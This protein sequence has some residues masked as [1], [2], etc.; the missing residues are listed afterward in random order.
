[1][2]AREIKEKIF[3][4]VVVILSLAAVLPVFHVFLS[5]IWNGLGVIMKAG[6]RFL[7]DVPPAPNAGLGGIAPSLAGTLLLAVLSSLLGIPLSLFAAVFAVEFPDN[8]LAKGVRVLSKALLE[9]PSVVV[10]MLVYAILVV[11][12]GRFSML[13]GALALA[14]MMIPYVTTYVEQALEGVPFTY[15]EAGFALGLSRPK[16]VFDIMVGIARRGILTG[17]LIGFA[18]VLGET[19]PL[20]FTLGRDR[21]NIPLGPLD[22]GDSISLLIFDYAQTPYANMHQVAWGAALVLTLMF[23]AVFLISRRFTE[24]V[25]L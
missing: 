13:A 20:L 23:L 8:P 21:Y 6:P 2:D 4:A 18:K 24:E 9:I 15:R 11:P 3:L 14:I 16:V 17:M 25:F 5:V 12:M 1:M 19:A 10:G 22:Y 7:L